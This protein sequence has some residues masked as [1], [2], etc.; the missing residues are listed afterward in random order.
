MNNSRT[1]ILVTITI[2][3][4]LFIPSLVQ[5]GMF[6]DG[7]TY[8][9][10]SKNLAF[11][12][13]SFSAP[14]YTETL[15]PVFHEHPPLVFY[16]QSWFF[17]LFG[18][19]FY[20]ERIFCLLIA[21]LSAIGIVLNW[22]LL[23]DNPKMKS[24]Y[25]IPIIFWLS[26]PLVSWSYKNNLLE[27]TMG[28]FSIYA[29]FFILKSLKES[30]VIFTL[31]GAILIVLAFLSKGVVGLFPLVAPLIF[32]ITYNERK[33]SALYF[34]FLLLF[35]SAISLLLVSVFPEIKINLVKYF[36]QQFIPSLSK[37]REITTNNRFKII[38]D[39][40]LNLA[41]PIILSVFF[42]IKKWKGKTQK[43]LPYKK[44]FLFFILIAIS[45]SIP[46]IISLKQRKFY[47]IPSIPF[48]A[49]SF[50]Y[51]L[52]RPIKDQI[53]RIP[54]YI[55]QWLNRV[56]IIV[57]AF[58]IIFS[59]VKFGDFS[60]D[61]ETIKDIYKISKHIPKGTVI[62]TTEDLWS[63]WGLVAY[64]S[65]IGSLS[66]DCDNKHEYFLLRKEAVLVSPNGY[67]SVNLKLENYVLLKR[68][69]V[70][71]LSGL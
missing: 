29:V 51:L 1:Y 61:E 43:K 52:Y 26:I 37:A 69:R 14:H 9:A 5:E 19:A 54:I 31:L 44:S 49:L 11:G 53:D 13:G 56:S 25:W 3:V 62:S 35:S 15:Y 6:L 70:N 46:L 20:T 40:T 63:D 8:S 55:L 60:R 2:F 57:L 58:V 59:T 48:Y 21:L 36:N 41:I 30:K 7:V 22:K 45:A 39:L 27:N 17:K 33:K 42:A 34:L 64:M 47:L 4:G 16:L 66:L 18:D 71:N 68:T 23:A 12:Y 32:G 10:I 28:V 67:D 24:A 65:R 38:F 50:S